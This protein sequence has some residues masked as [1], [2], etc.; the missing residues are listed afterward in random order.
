MNKVKITLHGDLGEKIGHNW[1]LAVK[2][3][4]E[5]IHAIQMISNEALYKYLIQ[6]DKKSIKY[7]VLI[8]G[9]DFV[10]EKDP[11]TLEDIQKSELCIKKEMETIDIV[12]L[13]EGAGKIGAIILGSLLIIV[14]AAIAIFGSFVG[15]TPLGIG[16]IMVGIGLLA[17]GVSALL[18]KPPSFQDFREIEGGGKTAYLFNGPENVTQEGGPVP[19]GYGKLLVGS[20]VISASYGIRD[21]DAAT[22]NFTPNY[23][24]SV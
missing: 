4:S 9:N 19:V 16:I 6:E 11:E 20:Q 2:S 15:A 21:I 23:N 12:P 14:G 1:N 8:N 18:A 13:I 3:V 7:R 10:A 5:A 17:A 24:L 22:K